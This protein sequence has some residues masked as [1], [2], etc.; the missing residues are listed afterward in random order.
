MKKLFLCLS[1]SFLFIASYAQDIQ[2]NPDFIS[3]EGGVARHSLPE[4]PQLLNDHAP[5]L[6]IAYGFATNHRKDDWMRYLNAQYIGVTILYM[7]MDNFDVIQNLTPKGSFGSYVGVLP[8][9][10]ARIFNT[11]R[12]AGYM[13]PSFG[14]CYQTKTWRDN[15]TLYNRFLGSGINFC[16]KLDYLTEIKATE[17][18][19]FTI[20]IRFIHYSNSAFYLPNTGMNLFAAK[21]GV[22]YNLIYAKK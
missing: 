1:A 4:N 5:T 10:Y 18:L 15:P 11:K 19:S 21:A 2:K 17:K 12:V 7:N 22:K 20:G 6:E 14:V 8:F 16:T 13:V 9:V 3:L